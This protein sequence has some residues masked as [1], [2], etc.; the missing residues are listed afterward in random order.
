NTGSI[1]F[2]VTP[3]TGT[4]TVTYTKNSN[5]QTTSIAATAGTITINNLGAGLYNNIRVSLNNCLSNSLGPIT[6]ADPNP[7]ATPIITAVD[8][9]CSGNTLNLSASTTSMGSATYNWIYPNGNTNTSQ[10]I[11]ISNIAVK[12]SGTYRVTV[13]IANCVSLAGTKYIRVDSTPSKPI[14]I[15]NSPV[16]SDSMI[17]ISANSYPFPVSYNWTKQTNLISTNQS[18]TITN[19]QAVNAGFYKIVVTSNKNCVALPDSVNVIIKPTP[20]I[21]LQD[22]INPNQCATP[23]GNIKL[24]GLL[25]NTSYQIVYTINSSIK[26]QTQTSNTTGILTIDTLR[27]GNYSNIYVVLNGC[28]SLSVGPVSLEDPNPPAT[29]IITSVDSICSG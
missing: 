5:N 8:S 6:L 1:S 24:N 20:I 16:C 11:A 10:N 2:N 9:I 13:T 15:S 19:A 4:F 26:T 25:P 28:P 14:I 7:P 12:D 22:S 17:N 29:P 27:A 3:T 18:F 21:A 23:T